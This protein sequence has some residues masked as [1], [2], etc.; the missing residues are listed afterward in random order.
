MVEVD[1]TVERRCGVTFVAAKVRNTRSTPQRVRVASTLDGPVWPPNDAESQSPEWVDGTWQS[2]IL[3]GQTRGMGFASP[4][5]PTES[6]ASIVSV[7]RA[8]GE[9]TD[10]S[11]EDVLAEL[12]DWS[13]PSDILLDTD[14]SDSNGR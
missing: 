1:T 14:D 9:T 2:T 6:P 11:D 5:E 10:E 8:T 3:P 4:A 7:S 12:D 13:P